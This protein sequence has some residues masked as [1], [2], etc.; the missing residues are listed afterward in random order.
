[1]SL[2]STLNSVKKSAKNIFTTALLAYS[3]S[4]AAEPYKIE[5]VGNQ[6]DCSKP[7][8]STTQSMTGGFASTFY[9]SKDKS[10]GIA[11]VSGKVTDDG[12]EIAY[13]SA[14][15]DNPSPNDL[16]INARE[17]RVFVYVPEGTVVNVTD[18][19]IAAYKSNELIQRELT[20]I[21]QAQGV[22]MRM[23]RNLL[24]NLEEIDPSKAATKTFTGGLLS[25]GLVEEFY[26]WTERESKKSTVNQDIFEE[27]L[28]KQI[29]VVRVDIGVMDRADAIMLKEMARKIK[30]TFESDNEKIPISVLYRVSVKENENNYDDR[31]VCEMYTTP[32][33]VPAKKTSPSNSSGDSLYDGVWVLKKPSE[34]RV[35]GLIIQNGKVFSVD[36]E[37]FDDEMSLRYP[38]RK[39][40]ELIIPERWTERGAVLDLEKISDNE[41]LFRQ[42]DGRTREQY[43]IKSLDSYL[44]E[45]V[46]K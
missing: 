30:I 12:L 18:K 16:Q 38:Q 19:N 41:I 29:D 35:R 36:F 11:Y 4:S 14:D 6:W 33:L 28:N 24:A 9:R 43:K 2:E 32:I 34:D 10:S 1:M 5:V 42:F 7:V 23:G 8:Q 44:K 3:L 22:V 26:N 20:N 46:R 45:N 13:S 37:N 27:M 31:G 40:T 21:D 15:P 39:K 25:F 17:S